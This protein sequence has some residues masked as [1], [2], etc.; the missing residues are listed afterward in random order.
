MNWGWFI[1]YLRL[2]AKSPYSQIAVIFTVMLM[3][4]FLFM[5]ITINIGRVSLMKVAMDNAADGAAL[6]V[7]SNLGSR[8]HYFTNMAGCDTDEKALIGFLLSIVLLPLSPL[9]LG[10]SIA[11]IATGVVATEVGRYINQAEFS[12][13]LSR[14]PESLQ[15]GESGI[16]YALGGTVND[17]NKIVDIHDEDADGITTDKIPYFLRWYSRRLD[18]VNNSTNRLDDIGAQLVDEIEKF[19]VYLVGERECTGRLLSWGDTYWSHVALGW[20]KT[21]TQKTNGIK[22]DFFEN[23]FLPFLGRIENATNGDTLSFWQPGEDRGDPDSNLNDEVD[24]VMY[25]IELFDDIFFRIFKKTGFF[26]L[27]TYTMGIKKRSIKI[28]ALL[29]LYYDY[30]HQPPPDPADPDWWTRLG[31]WQLMIDNWIQELQT[32]TPCLDAYNKCRGTCV[33]NLIICLILCGFNPACEAVCYAN[34]D[35]CFATCSTNYNTCLASLPSQD[36]I[37]SVIDSLKAFKDKVQEFRDKI[38]PLAEEYYDILDLQTDAL[39]AW[40]D[41]IGWHFVRVRR[42]GYIIPY[43]HAYTKLFQNC[44]G[45][46]NRCGPVW[47]EITRYDAKKSIPQGVPNPFW[48]M[49]F[50]KRDPVWPIDRLFELS[51][52]VSDRDGDG[53]LTISDLSD[54]QIRLVGTILDNYGIIEKSCACWGPYIDYIELVPEGNCNSGWCCRGI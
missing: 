5:I 7:A 3:V 19:D 16:Y 14:L 33:D 26:S 44:I 10:L 29:N 13:K 21:C 25:E 32:M 37:K 39:Y 1:N 53:L 2:K 41:S 48:V 11:L 8:S 47:I 17:P 45:A 50:A 4:V 36:E 34:R 27:I 54:T 52:G 9:A 18:A 12:R 23:T 15:I 22:Q 40:K 6:N 31:V 43:A 42:S 28:E 51:G 35:V 46:D 20:L 24:R 38:K 30:E 49:R